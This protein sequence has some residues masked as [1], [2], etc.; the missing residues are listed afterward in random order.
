MVIPIS[1]DKQDTTEE[2]EFK[3]YK[4]NKLRDIVMSLLAIIFLT[5]FA[6]RIEWSEVFSLSIKW[7]FLLLAIT[8]MLC[9][10]FLRGL[11]VYF[12]LGPLHGSVPINRFIITFLAGYGIGVI[13]P[14]KT[15]DLGAVEIFNRGAKIA[16]THSL[17]AML[18]VRLADIIVIGLSFSLILFFVIPDLLTKN[19]PSLSD[20]RMDLVRVSLNTFVVM[21]VVILIIFILIINIP[22]FGRWIYKLVDRFFTF[23]KFSF[24]KNNRNRVEEGITGFYNSTKKIQQ[25][26]PVMLLVYLCSTLRW[27]LEGY[28]VVLLSQALSTEPITLVEGLGVIS[29]AMVVGMVTF[30]PAGIGGGTL[31]SAL[32]LELVGLCPSE[33]GALTVLNTFLGPIFVILLGVVCFPFSRHISERL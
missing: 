26:K 28:I 10:L 8:L 22:V 14:A 7:N 20:E 16:P 27:L 18:I 13:F 23:M 32:F 4:K 17:A 24:W 21:I 31:S 12:A 2:N 33:A 9:S 3:L 15:G 29:V 1:L 5:I 19:L 30:T 25:N 6:I 11:R